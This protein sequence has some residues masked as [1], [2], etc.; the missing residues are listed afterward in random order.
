MTSNERRHPPGS[1]I[2]DLTGNS[3]RLTLAAL[4]HAATS[5]ARDL[6][7]LL[8]E[9]AEGS[10]ESGAC[11]S[12][13]ARFRA[14]LHSEIQKI[15]WPHSLPEPGGGVLAVSLIPAEYRVEVGALDS[16]DFRTW[17]GSRQRSLKRAL[18]EGAAFLGGVDISLNRLQNA[19]EHWCFHLYGFELPRPNFSG[20]V[21]LRAAAFRASILRHCPLAEAVGSNAGCRP[22]MV[23]ARTGRAFKEKALRVQGGVLPQVSIPRD[24][25]EDR[26]S[27]H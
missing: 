18:P 16:F 7:E 22:L 11:P 1:Q 10:C 3:L 4:R 17:K 9:C 23:G 14:R 13:N 6:A 24:E 8:T 15:A 5:E 27:V 26:T 19:D 20:Q 12:C 25:A 2:D 21:D